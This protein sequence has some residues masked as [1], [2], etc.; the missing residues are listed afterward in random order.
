[1]ARG[2]GKVLLTYLLKTAAESGAVVEAEFVRT[3]RNRLMYLT[4]KMAGFSEVQREGDRIIFRH[5]PSVVDPYPPHVKVVEP[6]S[7]SW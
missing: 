6:E 3:D 1:M 4:Y 5:D 2:V 7:R